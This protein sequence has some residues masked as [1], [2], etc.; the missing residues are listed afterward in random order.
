MWLGY[1][2]FSPKTTVW[3]IPWGW[4]VQWLG[5]STFTAEEPGSNP[6]WG[7]EISQATQPKIF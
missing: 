3:G 1:T 5:L 4:G 2:R 7:T 6:G